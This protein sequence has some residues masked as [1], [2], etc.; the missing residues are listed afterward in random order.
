MKERQRAE[1]L[2]QAI[3]ELI[4]G[5][6][7]GDLE[8]EELNELLVIARIRL[9][10]ARTAAQAGAEEEEAVWERILARI[11]QLRRQRSG[12]P[13]G[14]LNG[15]EPAG[16]LAV[17]EDPEHTEIRDLQGIVALRRHLAEEMALLSEAYRDVVWQRLQIRLLA[18]QDERRALFRLPFHRPNREAAA[19]AYAVDRLILGE[20][21]WQAGDPA[22][23]E[24]LRL[25]R[26][27]RAVGQATAAAARDYQG[28]VWARL[29]PRLM[30]R[31]MGAAGRHRLPTFG[32]PKLAAAGATAALLLALL[33]P[34]PA[35]GVQGHPLTRFARLVGEQVGVVETSA[36]PS[37][38]P[39]TRIVEGEDISLEEASA[40]L[41][42]PLRKP[43]EL[44]PGFVLVAS[45]HFP[46]GITADLGGTYMLAYQGPDSGSPEP[47]LILIYQ[48][49]STGNSIAVQEGSTSSFL[50]SDGTIATYVEGSWR[51][52]GAQVIWGEDGAQT[53]IFD[54]G[55]LRTIIHHLGGDRLLPQ[56][57]LA[58]AQSMVAA[59]GDR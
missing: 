27:R 51:A 9:D 55:G 17:D 56:D 30:A 58:I 23:D 13:N 50:L 52:A 28:R 44:P 2:A 45:R 48:E 10:A 8:D 38:P 20:P 37:L 1:R 25:A 19:V 3:E 24:L 36:P 21:L 39:P 42:L 18:A 5:R 49:R 40:I 57:L 54:R 22:L 6:L 43:T 7:P 35:T 59:G 31:L 41:G 4:Q 12:D 32:W 47:P 29:R 14:F 26:I 46:V 16:Y 15:S 33:G 11:S 34:L 53:L